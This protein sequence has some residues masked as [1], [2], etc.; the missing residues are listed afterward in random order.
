[1]LDLAERVATIRSRAVRLQRPRS[2]ARTSADKEY[3]VDNP[4]SRRCPVIAKARTELGFD[5]EGARR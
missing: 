2:C 5:A 3:L 4:Q 1:M